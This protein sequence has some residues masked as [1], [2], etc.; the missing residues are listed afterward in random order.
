MLS[1]PR[2]LRTELYLDGWTNISNRVRQTSAVTITRGRNS[3]ARA[4]QPAS[5]K[6]TL[7][8]SAGDFAPRNPLGAW[9]GKLS[10]NTPMRVTLGLVRDKFARTVAAG[11]GNSDSGDAWTFVSSGSSSVTPGFGQHTGIGAGSLALSY[12]AGLTL[13]DLEI[14]ATF[15]APGVADVTGGAIEATLVIRGQDTANYYCVRLYVMA[16]E[17]VQLMLVLRS[18]GSESLIAGPV[19]LPIVWAAGRAVRIKAHMEAGTIRAK[20]WDATTAEPFEWPLAT[21]RSAPLASGWVGVR[22]DR[23]ATNTNAGVVFTYAD[24]DVRSGRFHGELSDLSP[25]WNENHRDRSVPVQ[26]GGTWRR[27]TGRDRPELSTLR[28]GYLVDTLNRPVAYWPAEDGKDAKEVSSALPGKPGMQVFGAQQFAAYT[29]FACSQPVPTF[30]PDTAWVGFVPDYPG[31]GQAQVRLLLAV[32]SSGATDMTPIMIVSTST[33]M[34]WSVYYTAGGGLRVLGLRPD[35]TSAADSTAA[36]ALNGSAG[37]VSLELKQNGSGV[38]WTVGTLAINAGSG[39]FSSG[40]ATTSTLGVVQSVYVAPNGMSAGHITVQSTV[41]SLFDIQAQLDAYAG[42]TTAARFVRLCK[43]TGIDAQLVGAAS[44]S[45]AMGPQ[46]P[47]TLPALLTE[48]A[49][50]ELGELFE[51]AYSPA[52]MFRPHRTMTTQ[53]P[54]LVLDYAARQVSAPLTP[55]DDDQGLTNDVTASQPEAGSYQVTLDTGRLSTQ[56]PPAGVGRYDTS[57]TVNVSRGTQL[58]DV[59]GW[60]LHE[61]TADQPR[62]PTVRVDLATAGLPGVAVLDAGI[63]D[64]VRITHLAAALLYDDVDQLVRGYT[65][66]YADAY[67]HTITWSCEPGEP[68]RV[69]TLDD[70]TYGRLDSDASSVAAGVSSAATALSVFVVAGSA[71]WTTDPAD[72]PFDIRVGGEVMRVTAVAGTTSPQTFTVT[73]AVNGVAKAHVVGERVGLATPVYLGK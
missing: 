71:L 16:D 69:W 1:Y 70:P 7:D 61:G 28:R 15:S 47:N 37:R 73:R 20:A 2:P 25:V 36:F 10:R 33:G 11:W 17:T 6:L 63:G 43:E 58:A 35:G 53:A 27:L 54:A 45:A 4:P 23:E 60:L 3:E 14:A 8:D 34:S 22:S 55:V 56:Q 48:C 26:A 50:A 68:W 67:S 41:D 46:R 5:C 19:T 57:V 51:S 52:L 72:T 62:Y 64:L 42:E 66:Q 9:Y 65:E 31:T 13:A 29:G 30:G 49:D 59:A 38:D 12:L 40:T 18:G 39:G 24:V 21:T 32:P 44:A